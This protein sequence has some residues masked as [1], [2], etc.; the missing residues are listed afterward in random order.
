MVIS[1]L[2]AA[3]LLL[4][5]PH[6]TEQPPDI[7]RVTDGTA[8]HREL[9]QMLGDRSFQLRE[10]AAKELTDQ[11]VAAK[12]VLTEALKDPDL[13]IRYRVHRILRRVLEDAFEARLTAFI[14]DV[15]GSRQI[16]LPG[17]KPFRD[18]VGG[19]RDARGM[20]AAMTRYEQGLLAAYE[21]Q[22]P[23]TQ[24][25][26]EARAAWLKSQLYSSNPGTVP[27]P[28]L[29][30]LLLI[31]SDETVKDHSRR[32]SLLYQLLSHPAAVKSIGPTTRP[33]CFRTLLEK[34]AN[35]ASSN[36]STYGMRVVLKY[37]L[38]ETG[39]QQA[40][41]LLER[42]TPSSST[43]QYGIITVGRFGSAEHI[44]L[45]TPLLENKTV[46]SRWSNRALKENG[47]INVEV[48]DVALVVLLRLSNRDPTQYG[49]KLLKENPETLYHVYTFGFIDDEQREAAHKKWAA[50][51]DAGDK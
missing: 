48:R 17:W 5:V 19:D 45:L 2:L 38:K 34:W 18:L 46:C 21:K 6:Q 8:V 20:F 31:G 15:D 28:S 1:S 42:G 36:G 12:A 51:S 32:A 3:S 23:E 40:T 11:G 16:S 30:T 39:L 29:A 13:E 49:F 47:T 33:S 25:L 27:P 44:R 7:A 35:S 26:F 24:E 43:L 41:K 22:V 10:R 9:I 50:E 14:A 4:Q 37:D